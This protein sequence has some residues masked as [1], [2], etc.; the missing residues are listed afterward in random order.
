MKGGRAKFGAFVAA[1]NVAK[2]VCDAL[3]SICWGDDAQVAV[4]GCQKEYASTH[5]ST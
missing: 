1:I 2:L 5:G 3:H 4:I